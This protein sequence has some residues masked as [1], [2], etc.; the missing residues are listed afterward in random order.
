MGPTGW[1]GNTGPIGDTGL[2]GNTGPTG[3][4]GTT[5]ALGFGSMS[6]DTVDSLNTMIQPGTNSIVTRTAN[7]TP[8]RF[9]SNESYPLN[10][11][12][13]ASLRL[14]GA[15]PTSNPS[16]S[17]MYFG[18][19]SR[20]NKTKGDILNSS[21]EIVPGLNV[22][23]LTLGTG[24]TN[25]P[26]FSIRESLQTT[27][28]TGSNALTQNFTFPTAGT[29][30][31]ASP[32]GNFT[33][34]KAGGTVS[35][36]SE[37]GIIYVANSN[38]SSGVIY[39]MLD[40]DV[41][42]RS[43]VPW[44]TWVNTY[45]TRAAFSLIYWNN[46]AFY[47][48]GSNIGVPTFSLT[49]GATGPAGTGL[50]GNTGPTGFT[51]QVGPG[52][53][54]V[55]RSHTQ[56]FHIPPENTM[57]LTSISTS[58]PTFFKLFSNETF[59][60]SKS[61]SVFFRFSATFP[62]STFFLYFGLVS[63][64]VRSTYIPTD[65]QV[66]T[67]NSST[68]GTYLFKLGFVNNSNSG[69]R[70]ID[71]GNNN[72]VLPAGQWV[73]TNSSTIGISYEPTSSGG[74]RFIYMINGI[75]V[76]TSTIVPQTTIPPLGAALFA[77]AGFKS[78]LFP[79]NSP[80]GSITIV[81]GST[82]GSTGA[83]GFGSLSIDTVNSTNVKI[84]DGT[85]N[86][87][88]ALLSTANT[89]PRFISN[90]S[91]PLNVACSAFIKMNFGLTFANVPRV[92]LGLVSS[93]NKTI[94]TYTANNG[95]GVFPGYYVMQV[96]P[97]AAGASTAQPMIY[98]SSGTSGIT[99]SPISPLYSSTSSTEITTLFAPYG[100]GTQQNTITPNSTLGVTYVPTSPTTGLISYLIDG[101]VIGTTRVPFGTWSSPNN[102]NT[103]LFFVYSVGDWSPVAL[104]IGAVLGTPTFFSSGSM[105]PTGSTGALGFGNLS[106]DSLN[107]TNVM[108]PPGT[109][110]LFL[111]TANSTAR[112]ISNQS[113]P[114]NLACSAFIRM[115]FGSTFLNVGRIAFGLVS[116][117]NKTVTTE[118]AGT[119]A[120]VFPGYYVMRVNPT[121]AS[122][123]TA[124]LS[125]YVSTSG[126]AT[127]APAY[128]SNSSGVEPRDTNTTLFAPYGLGSTVSNITPNSILGVTYVPTSLTTGLISYLI[129]GTVIGTTRVPFGTWSSPNNLNTTLSFVYS[130]GETI[131]N[132][133]PAN[134]EI[135]TP[136]FFSLGSLGPTGVTGQTGQTGATGPTGAM[137]LGNWS[138]DT[139]SSQNVRL[140][141]GT[142]NMVT[143]AANTASRFFSNE[144]YPLNV[145][146]SAFLRM[147][148]TTFPTNGNMAF[149]LTS[150]PNKTIDVATGTTPS[151]FTG[152]NVFYMTFTGNTITSFSIRES[153]NTTIT[154]QVAGVNFAH[155]TTPSATPL[156]ITWIA[157][158]GTGSP[159]TVS[160]TPKSILGLVYL[161]NSPTSGTVY[162]MIDGNVVAKSIIPFGTWIPVT[163][164]P[165]TT[166]RMGYWNF[167][168]SAISAGTNL[169]VATFSQNVGAT[170]P[171]GPAGSM[172]PTGSTGI[173]GFG[174]FS[175]DTIKIANAVT[176]GVYAQSTNSN[177]L[178]A[179]TY[180]PNSTASH[181]FPPTAITGYTQSS[182]FP[183]VFTNEGYTDPFTISF[184][185][186]STN[187]TG[188]TDNV[189]FNLY[190]GLTTR[191]TS[192]LTSTNSPVVK[193]KPFFGVTHSATTPIQQ[194]STGFWTD[195]VWTYDLVPAFDYMFSIGRGQK[196]WNVTSIIE[197]SRAQGDNAQNY[198]ETFFS[199]GT[200]W[201]P[202]PQMTVTGTPNTYLNISYD[203]NSLIF[204]IN[205]IKWCQKII[206]PLT[207]PLYGA[208]MLGILPS[209]VRV[210]ITSFA[211]IG[212]SAQGP[213]GPMGS[214]VLS[215]KPIDNSASTDSNTPL[216]T[217]ANNIYLSGNVVGFKRITNI[218]S[219]ED[220]GGEWAF[221]T[222]PIVSST[223]VN[224]LITFPNGWSSTNVKR[225]EVGL[226]Q[227]RNTFGGTPG[228]DITQ[229]SP[230]LSSPFENSNFDY[231]IYIV[232][233]K[234]M[235]RATPLVGSSS[236][237]LIPSNILNSTVTSAYYGRL[238]VLTSTGSYTRATATETTTAEIKLLNDTQQG[239]WYSGPTNR[240]ISLNISIVFSETS[241]SFYLN[242]NVIT[243][244][245]GKTVPCFITS[246]PYYA[247]VRMLSQ[248]PTHI[249]DSNIVYDT[250]SMNLLPIAGPTGSFSPT[251]LTLYSKA[252]VTTLNLGNSNSV[253][254]IKSGSVNL[255]TIDAPF[256]FSANALT[257]PFVLNFMFNT[258][259]AASTS[260]SDG[261]TPSI[262]AHAIEFAVGLVTN[263]VERNAFNA[264][265][266][267]T[268]TYGMMVNGT[269]VCYKTDIIANTVVGTRNTDVPISISPAN[270]MKASATASQTIP[271]GGNHSLQIK[272]DGENMSYYVNGI[273]VV[274]G[275]Q[276]YTF[277]PNNKG[278]YYLVMSFANGD[279]FS[280]IPQGQTVPPTN[281]TLQV[282][283]S[284]IFG[285]TGLLGT[286]L[287][288]LTTW[289]I[290][291]FTLPTVMPGVVASAGITTF[292]Y[293]TLNSSSSNPEVNKTAN[294]A[295]FIYTAN[296]NA[297]KAM[298]NLTINMNS[299]VSFNMRYIVFDSMN[300]T[301]LI[302]P[303]IPAASALG[304]TTNLS[305]G[306]T[307]KASLILTHL[308]RFVLQAWSNGVAN[309][310]LTGSLVIDKLPV[311]QGGGG[312]PQAQRWVTVKPIPKRHPSRKS[313]LRISRVSTKKWD[314][315]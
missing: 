71:E 311:A 186:D 67:T 254:V 259:T 209:N 242:G 4:I 74:G 28:V 150:N 17:Y 198:I 264:Q 219:N 244:K 223:S 207:E 283:M 117:Q 153:N 275:S 167:G 266:A 105:G 22:M 287:T 138:I 123:S 144:S 193:S 172:G 185:L 18:F 25:N 195:G 312:E 250:V 70:S 270:S 268:F 272:F 196:G 253:S 260:S 111:R 88:F 241:V 132:S 277:T 45:Q 263:L 75:V 157:P 205:N 92:I 180:A 12:F 222:A 304:T 19:V 176:S 139:A 133:F 296:D 98:A 310:P 307:M 37:L 121:A 52:N 65:S 84:Q 136:T 127:A 23:M 36:T 246:A 248:T 309:A 282:T 178:T 69:G 40:G 43:N 120:S 11:S 255:D 251:N 285:G 213:P 190:V 97:T 10:V 155:N 63:N 179:P 29:T 89:I 141:P 281:F 5:G 143:V 165:N 76:Y 149:G 314:R 62:N 124:N 308:D 1:T 290:S 8:I 41:I 313:S 103:T 233:E 278:P 294:G 239:I 159:P 245:L 171:S 20:E 169:G 210:A 135:G 156:N 15:R 197:N 85:N 131:G 9:L 284:E 267:N 77:P 269:T 32:V 225:V 57:I 238:S 116:S 237:T 44:G 140:Q 146:F 31:P 194:D 51:G 170:G 168:I 162:Y 230:K 83:L 299:S 183:F 34:L 234:F 191:K 208:M 274:N 94:T 232:N 102:L 30:M 301:K 78:S 66:W 110:S 217:S 298:V 154:S 93:Q 49:V 142:D 24:N 14:G 166:L 286:T 247:G 42:A 91:Y 145:P 218:S 303:T 73:I 158:Y 33:W 202:P 235:I 6:M 113:Y 130:V 227:I 203:G 256:V 46:N 177:R 59:P 201:A 300:I 291:S 114:L 214:S 271:L 87:I 90:E 289:N 86:I 252:R 100:L 236:S 189:A 47:P 108:I 125:F 79:A 249:V 221:I 161:P 257:G 60:P 2:T 184:L 199:I 112:F 118:S 228:S 231:S 276:R 175:W 101:T 212:T 53:W 288:H 48:A 107:S 128:P 134:T 64:N 306:I 279:Q 292:L 229:E 104:P 26:T 240:Q 220:I 54:T 55:D 206:G 163:S 152:L 27:A 188:S 173:P 243:T 72:I 21:T 35:S 224:F 115:N 302:G 99:A 211:R 81:E 258:N 61:Y 68:S 204:T 80:I 16:V 3:I 192:S 109:N 164:G 226:R 119:S 273:L 126:L 297:S 182:S 58:T 200:T 50:T 174:T 82:P 56:N 265:G 39:Y 280:S 160:I 7:G 261:N 315:K 96:N 181:I 148:F 187:I 129:D 38:G 13:S 151:I 216:Y 137:G 215:I 262:N 106:M 305:F 95:T 295:S 293:D 122:A 147:N